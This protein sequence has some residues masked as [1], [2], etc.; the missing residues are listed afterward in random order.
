MNTAVGPQVGNNNSLM[1]KLY[2]ANSTPGFS[3]MYWRR[4]RTLLDQFVQTND[5]PYEQ[6]YIER[7]LDE[8]IALMDPHDDPFDPTPKP[9][10]RNGTVLGTDDADL[11]YNKWGSWS[12]GNGGRLHAARG[13]TMREHIQ[14]VKDTFLPARRDYLYGQR[15]LP[16]AQIG[17]PI[18]NFGVIEVAPS[19]GDKK[20]Q[21]IQL[22]NPHDTAVDISGWKLTEAVDFTFPG[23]TVSR[24]AGPSTSWRT[25]TRFGRGP[26][27]PAAGRACS[28]SVVG[29]ANCHPKANR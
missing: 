16:P 24:R 21:Y 27:V 8:M 12:H 4:L 17:N 14:R 10:A 25:R 9:P 29:K 20:Q 11:D 26:R 15:S 1:G 19:G 5:T 18:L 13:E 28:W 7:R 22:V 2:Q 3:E 6:R 23:G